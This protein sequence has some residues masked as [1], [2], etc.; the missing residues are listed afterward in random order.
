MSRGGSQYKA[1]GFALLVGS[2][3]A[4]LPRAS[5]AQCTP[6]V[7]P[8]GTCASALSVVGSC[9]APT[10]KNTFAVT[11][12]YTSST[13]MVPAP[14]TVVGW[15]V[16]ASASGPGCVTSTMAIS[17]QAW[18]GAVTTWSCVGSD[19]E[20]VTPGATPSCYALASPIPVLA[21]DEIGAQYPTGACLESSGGCDFNYAKTASPACPAS[22]STTN[23]ACSGPQIW[24]AL[25][26]TS[27]DGGVDA[28]PQ[29]SGADAGSTGTDSGPASDSGPGGG[30]DSSVPADGGPDAAGFD[31]ATPADAG[32]D[33]SLPDSSFM[34]DA[35]EDSGTPPAWDSGFGSDGAAPADAGLTRDESGNDGGA[36]WLDPNLHVAC[37]CSAPGNACLAGLA[38]PWMLRRRRVNRAHIARG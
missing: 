23:V 35:G 1:A 5:M 21:G 29:D 8:P 26:S 7:Q 15:C 10:T 2:S 9:C 16:S 6:C 4:A 17:L 37:G 25:C 19:T 38:I 14:G 27:S 33:G 18:R 32:S 28:G 30:L 36:E 22:L 3:L 12:V 24:I 34:N 11:G 20:S 31:A 13:G